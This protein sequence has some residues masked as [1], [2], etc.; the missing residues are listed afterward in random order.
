MFGCMGSKSLIIKI[1]K[2]LTS[3]ICCICLAFLGYTLTKTDNVD[4]GY[5]QN[6]LHAA[7]TLNWGLEG[8]KPINVQLNEAN[9][10]D[11]VYVTIHDTVTVNNTKYVRV[12]VPQHTTDTLYV[13]MNSPSEVDTCTVS[14]TKQESVILL[15]VDGQVVYDSNQSDGPEKP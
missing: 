5:D 12:P 15:T 11:T 7:T 1:M 13:P 6:A 9:L 14:G 10:K 2:K 3:T 8:L 4:S